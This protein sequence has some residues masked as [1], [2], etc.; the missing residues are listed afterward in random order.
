MRGPP[1]NMDKDLTNNGKAVNQFSTDEVELIAFF[2]Q[3]ILHMENGFI[4]LELS[5]KIPRSLEGSH[6]RESQDKRE[7]TIFRFGKM[8]EKCAREATAKKLSESFSFF[9][10]FPSSMWQ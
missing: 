7:E 9:S 1:V 8:C 2:Y 5:A 6:L 4:Y 3:P 10:I